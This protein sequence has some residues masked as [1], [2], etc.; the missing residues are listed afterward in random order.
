MD[1]N[2]YDGND[3]DDDGNLRAVFFYCE[4]QA[5][6]SLSLRGLRESLSGLAAI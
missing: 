4:S 2:G 1:D 3:G 6:C 5:N